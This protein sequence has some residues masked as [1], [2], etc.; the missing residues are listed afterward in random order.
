MNEIRKYRIWYADYEGN[1]HEV[2]GVVTQCPTCGHFDSD[3]TDPRGV[4]IIL[5]T[6]P[7]KGAYTQQREGRY[8]LVLGEWT[9]M[10]DD[11]ILDY[12]LESGTLMLGRTIPNEVYEE[13]R[14]E[15]KALKQKWISEW[16][17]SHD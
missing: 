12:W 5:Q 14:L 3:L 16:R 15:A 10:D 1:R 17:E 7:K 2:D 8:Q 11:G 9:S 13:I 6:C 4:Q